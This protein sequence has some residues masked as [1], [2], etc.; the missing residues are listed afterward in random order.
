M[1]AY[2][3]G[4][5]QVEALKRTVERCNT[6]S[7]ELR[8]CKLRVE[9]LEGTV[10]A[11]QRES[12]VLQA[13]RAVLQEEITSLRTESKSKS[14]EIA[15]LQ[16][17]LAL[18]KSKSDQQSTQVLLLKSKVAELEDEVAAAEADATAAREELSIRT[19]SERNG[20]VSSEVERLLEENARL[21]QRVQAMGAERAELF[22]PKTE[23]SQP[24]ADAGE[25]R[26]EG[27]STR[28]FALVANMRLQVHCFHTLKHTTSALQSGM[29]AI[30]KGHPYLAYRK[31]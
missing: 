19:N 3:L 29:Q 10:M 21:S 23:E 24:E 14:Y 16:Q 2:C 20:D 13:G 7:A 26:D 28:K 30:R 5:L 18:D 4:V 6:E 17:T 11:L 9:E 1:P 12:K 22:V 31:T 8:A 27:K 25:V 15:T